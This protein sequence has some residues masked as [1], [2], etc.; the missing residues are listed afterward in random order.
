MDPAFR[1]FLIRWPQTLAVGAITLAPLA[2]TVWALWLL[3]KLAALLGALVIRPLTAWGGSE[4]GLATTILEILTALII[5]TV[6]GTL[7]RG[8]AGKAVG[9]AVDDAIGR[10]PIGRTIYSSAQKLIAS[11][12]SPMEKAQ[13][14][15]LIEFPSEEMKTVGL[16]TQIFRAADSGEELAAVYVPTT[17][18]PTSG[19]V[20]IVPV[21]RLIWLDWTL[22]E[23]VQFVVS[24]GVTAPEAIKYRTRGRPALDEVGPR[25]PEEIPPAP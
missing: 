2:L 18:N 1:Q 6:V 14:V 10:I 19:Y 23:A 20:E 5:L 21:D 12:Q 15:V 9:R 17:P 7:A 16:V 24:A 25:P 13:K 4:P 3:A 8:A 11:F 22:N